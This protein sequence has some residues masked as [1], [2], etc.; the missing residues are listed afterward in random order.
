MQ[1]IYLDYNATAPIRPEVVEAV[2]ASMGVTGNPSSVHAEGRGSR[3]IVEDAR[4][5]VAA[6]T[7]V[8]TAQVIFNGGATEGNNTI[9]SGYHGAAII[10]GSMEHPSVNEAA[11]ENARRI[12]AGRSGVLDSGAFARMLDESA[13]A[14]VS[15]QYVNSETGVI[16]PVA[17]LAA[18]AK[19]KG[20]LVHCDAV[21]AAGRIDLA[22]KTLGVDYMTLSAHKFGGPQG[23][24]ALIFREGLQIPKF[25]R[26]G[27]QEKRQRA[28]TENVA[29]IAGFGMAARLAGADIDAYQT[30]CKTLQDR[31]ES[32]LRAIAPDII[33]LGE[34]APRVANTTATLL[35]G[36]A[37]E[38]QL[39]AL[40]LEGIAV[41]SGSACS[42]GSF[43]P[44]HVLGAMGFDDNAA[45]SGL[46]FS[47]G[48]ATTTADID[49]ALAAFEKMLGR[50]RK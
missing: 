48:W 35:P 30:R 5:Y 21:Q 42:S 25:M 32:G 39:M 44:S 45:R 31:L 9:L 47:T 13:P 33:I 4:A 15:I 16:Q 34:D 8:R 7:G 12:P 41:S 28:G 2:T 3:K 27:G 37:G 6:L 46:R 18:L 49:T 10:I 26:G 50:L 19:A 17:E 43:K 36:I 38:T 14:L 29:A 1:R 40:D 20:A 23:V 24:G 22:F 11:P